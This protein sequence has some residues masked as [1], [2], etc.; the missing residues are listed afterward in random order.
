MHLDVAGGSVVEH[1][2]GRHDLPGRVHLD[3]E[4]AAGHLGDAPGEVL[5]APRA[6]LVD[7]QARG[8]GGGHAPLEGPVLARPE[9]GGRAEGARGRAGERPFEKRTPLHGLSSL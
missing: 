3:L 6:H 9:H 1:L 8:I 4:A 5:G 7:G 2:E